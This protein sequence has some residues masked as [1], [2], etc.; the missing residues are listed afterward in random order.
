MKKRGEQNWSKAALPVGTIRL[1]KHSAG[2]WV[3]LVKVRMGGQKS[4]RWIAVARSWWLQHRGPIPHGHR[5]VHRDGNPLND[6]PGNYIL[7]TADDVLMLSRQWDASVDARNRDNQRRA[8]SAHNRERGRILRTQRIWTQRWYPVDVAN[9]R[10]ENVCFRS[11]VQVMRY[12]GYSDLGPMKN[13]GGWLRH[14][15]G[16]PELTDGSAALMAVLC[17][18]QCAPQCVP[19]SWRHPELL[20]EVNAIKAAYGLPA[21]QIDSVRQAVSRLG[22]LGYAVRGQRGRWS[23]TPFGRAQRREG[24]RRAPLRGTTILARWAAMRY[25]PIENVWCPLAG[26]TLHGRSGRLMVDVSGAL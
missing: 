6:A 5:V 18:P 9:G 16:W 24:D 8:T 11:R 23:P 12:L 15:L 26:S 3:R 14:V 4:G 21:Q 7:A 20:A 22:K 19:T 10:V 17:V 2:H 13:G 1:R 25:F